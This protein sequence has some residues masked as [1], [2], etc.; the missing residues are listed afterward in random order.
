MKNQSKIGLGSVQFGTKYGI[1]NSTG[2]STTAEVRQILD[3]AIAHDIDTIDTAS[4]YGDAEEVLGLIGVSSF[5]VISKFSPPTKEQSIA[6]QLNLSLDK[7][8]T[9]SLYAYL[10]HRPEDV[11]ANPEQWVEVDELKKSGLI[12]KIGFSFNQTHELESILQL[13]MYP[14]IIQVPFNF[15]DNRF[16]KYFAQ[17]KEINCEIHTR[18]T[19]LQG[20]FFVP[21]DRLNDFFN[22]VKTILSDLQIRY[23]ESLPQALLNYVLSHPLIDKV[24]IGVETASQLRLNLIQNE[25]VQLEPLPITRNLS[26]QI[27][28]PMYWPK[29]K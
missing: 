18:S 2:K 20:L 9:E 25:E 3:L 8:Q 10:A 26:K 1:S 5:K 15:F 12:K 4:G 17:L 22:P 7:L 6:K 13:K 28:M 21:T 16:E 23:K 14:D 11:V 29:N 19:F 24:I 27:L